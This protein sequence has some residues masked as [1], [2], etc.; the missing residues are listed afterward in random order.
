LLQGDESIEAGLKAPLGILAASFADAARTVPKLKREARGIV[1][2]EMVKRY[3]DIRMFGAVLTAGTNAGQVRGPMQLTFA[4]SIDAI[5]PRDVLITR[6]AITKPS[7]LLRK[8]TE[9]GRKAIVPYGLYRLH[10]FYS[11]HLARRRKEDGTWEGT[12]SESDL[13]DFWEALENMFEFDR[14]AARGE[15]IVRGLY[16]FTHDNEK[17][18]A[19][20]H[21]LFD[22]ISV[23]SCG[24]KLARSFDEYRSGISAPQAGRVEGYPGVT[25]SWVVAEEAVAAA[26]AGE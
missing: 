2:E 12:V 24:D 1:K 4:R 7:D 16:V 5:H 6:V 13:G 26:K 15:M 17:G 22:L 3:Y 20:S 10:G 21:K 11:S 19:A 8:Q 18:N 9:M 25:L 14:S 23:K